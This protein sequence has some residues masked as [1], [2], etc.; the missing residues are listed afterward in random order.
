[1]EA[2][3]GIKSNRVIN[4]VVRI[5]YVLCKPSKTFS[6]FVKSADTNMD[7]SYELSRGL[8][9]ECCW[10]AYMEFSVTKSGLLLF[11]F[12]FLILNIW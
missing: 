5:T 1:M 7:L 3:C 10:G 9:G 11:T 4:S 12:H 8:N 2:V 6:Y